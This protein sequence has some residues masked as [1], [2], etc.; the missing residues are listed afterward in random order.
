MAL[1]AWRVADHWSSPSCSNPGHT[2]L[3]PFLFLR[4]RREN[5]YQI[6]SSWYLAWYLLCACFGPWNIAS[7]QGFPLQETFIHI[8][9]HSYYRLFKS[10]QKK[11]G[12]KRMNNSVTCQLTVC[13]WTAVLRTQHQPEFR[14]I[15]TLTVHCDVVKSFFSPPLK[16]YTCPQTQII[17]LIMQ[18]IDYIVPFY[19]NYSISLELFW[20]SFIL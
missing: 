6:F 7:C 14:A 15:L 10:L 2:N 3:S 18:W 20:N 4:L 5:P 19:L 9:R 11:K 12:K 8:T 13:C 1:R 16:R 17:S